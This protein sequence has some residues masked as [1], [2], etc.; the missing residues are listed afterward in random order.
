MESNMFLLR[1]IVFGAIFFGSGFSNPQPNGSNISQEV[2]IGPDA[3]VKVKGSFA[4]TKGTTPRVT[5]EY[6]FYKDEVFTPFSPPMTQQIK[7]DPTK[8]IGTFSAPS[9]MGV[10]GVKIAFK[11]TLYQRDSFFRTRIAAYNIGTITP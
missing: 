2:S 11:S 6:G 3:M 4:F 7:I 10:F 1:S 9:Y 5:V 8:A